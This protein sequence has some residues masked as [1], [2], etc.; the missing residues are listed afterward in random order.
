MVSGKLRKSGHI[1]ADID[2]P[3]AWTLHS[4]DRG[5]L[6]C[7]YLPDIIAAVERGEYPAENAGKYDLNLQACIQLVESKRRG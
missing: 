6:Y 2:S 7:R 4:R 1:R 5:E 3:D